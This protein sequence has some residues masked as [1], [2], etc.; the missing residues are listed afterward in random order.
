M[1]DLD[2][3]DID[4]RMLAMLVAVVDEQSITRAAERLGVTQS[5]VSHGLDRL[6]ALVGDALVVKS[7]RGIAPTSRAVLLADRARH[8]LDGLRALAYVGE[9]DPA[10]LEGAVQIAANPMQRDL[11]LPRFFAAVHVQAPRLSLRVVPSDVPSADMLRNAECHLVISP[12]PP[13]AA[14]IVH[15]R[16]FEDRYRVYF[17]PARRQAPASLD[18]YER[19]E[20]VSVL[21]GPHRALEIDRLLD[22]RGVRR[23]VVVQ[24]ADFSGVRPFLADTTRLATLPGLLHIWQM[25]GLAHTEPPLELPAMPMYALWHARHQ[26]DAMH[27]WL[28][29]TLDT[30][31]SQALSELGG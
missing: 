30:V 10:L 11:L 16:L 4:G 7:G 29:A 9:F 25:Q 3:L 1:S 8:L 27:Q 20:H 22:E 28:R 31:V 24:V 6:R 13:D 23:R 14:D 18:D 19:A 26:A 12:R 5:A 2:P 17:D 21:H 15:K